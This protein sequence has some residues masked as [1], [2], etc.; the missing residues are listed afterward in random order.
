MVAL[1]VQPDYVDYM[2]GHIV[3]TYDDIQSLGVER[4]R[5]IYASAGLAIRQKTQISKIE[6]IKEMIRAM[7]ENPEQIL[8]K[9]ALADGAITREESLDDYQLA[10]LRNQL[11]QL[12]KQ[13]S[14]STNAHAL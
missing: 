11:K 6:T 10:V 12:I 9:D 7:G 1:G 3:D 5:K 2:M 14:D 13:E 4:L 8:A